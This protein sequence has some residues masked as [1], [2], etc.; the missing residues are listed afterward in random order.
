MSN[1][2]DDNIL[3]E[4][5][6]YV[7]ARDLIRYLILSKGLE[8]EIRK[9]II[10]R[11][12]RNFEYEKSYLLKARFPGPKII[13]RRLEEGTERYETICQNTFINLCSTWLPIFDA[14]QII[15]NVSVHI[16]SLN[17]NNNNSNSNSSSNSGSGSEHNAIFVSKGIN[18]YWKK[19][20]DNYAQIV[21]SNKLREFG[22]FQSYMVLA[23]VEEVVVN[24]GVLLTA[25]EEHWKD[26]L[27][28]VID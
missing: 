11:I 18:T 16:I 25:M 9:I 1:N 22:D 2:S 10:N 8:H 6:Y 21:V 5:L 26:D 20:I 12:Q 23:F 17:D 28:S 7:P 27:A 14:S 15:K 4:I 19:P 24:A 13:G 3:L